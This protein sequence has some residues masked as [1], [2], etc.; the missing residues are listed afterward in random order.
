METIEDVDSDNEEPKPKPTLLPPVIKPILKTPRT[1][2]LG[3]ITKPLE[4]ELREKLA[5]DAVKRILDSEKDAAFEGA[6]RVRM[7]IITSI[8][9]TFGLRVREGEFL[10]INFTEKMFR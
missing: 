3:E 8:A 1:L 4:D 2:K 7:K 9:T 10:K 6:L 5:V